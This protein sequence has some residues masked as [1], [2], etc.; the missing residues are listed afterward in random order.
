M[1]SSNAQLHYYQK[2][3]STDYHI[4]SILEYSDVQFALQLAQH[5]HE[6]WGSHFD[7]YM[8]DSALLEIVLG[9]T[10]ITATT[11]DS[12]MRQLNALREMLET[13]RRSGEV[14]KK[15]DIRFDRVITEK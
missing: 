15:I 3:M 7:I 13:V 9:H 12:H 5:V 8:H 4:G 10:T 14:Y 2:L 6:L 1:P 11:K